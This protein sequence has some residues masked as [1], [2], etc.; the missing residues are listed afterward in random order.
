MTS[1]PVKA[2]APD[3]PLT[4]GLMGGIAAGK[5]LVAELFEQH[6]L[7]RLDADEVSR[8]ITAKPEIQA[9][10]VDRFGPRA[11]TPDGQL[12]RKW[13]A[14]QVFTDSSGRRDL[15]ALTHPAIRAVLLEQLESAL[16]AG[17]SVI[18]DA[19]LLIETR[20]IDRCDICVYVDTADSV[21]RE[22]ARSRGWNEGELERR[23]ANQTELS[24]KKSRCAITITNDRAIQDTAAQ[25]AAA[26]ACLGGD[27]KNEQNH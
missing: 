10:L 13:L 2:F 14:E 19:P 22:R 26:L 27:A 4:I 6:G 15:E 7:S 21:R 18:L 24:V 25:V 12:D 8:E 1:D 20:L 16:A 3:R 23:E 5:S 9:Q 17:Q 11:V